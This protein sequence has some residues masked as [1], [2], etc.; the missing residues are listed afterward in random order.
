MNRLTILGD[1]A[2]RVSIRTVGSPRVTG[3]SVV[4]ASTDEETVR[5]VLGPSTPKWRDCTTTDAA[6]VVDLLLRHGIAVGAMS[7]NK[8]TDHWRAFAEDSQVLQDAIVNQSR[9]AAG[10]AKPSVVLSFI[11]LSGSAAIATGLALRRT[12]GR[13][14]SGADGLDPIERYLIFDTEVSGAESVEVF[15]AFW[16][17]NRAP[18]SRLAQLGVRMT[19]ADVQLLSEQDEPLLLLADY[20]AG[21]IHSTLLPDPGKLPMPVP[22]QEAKTLT[23]KLHDAGLLEVDNTNFDKSYDEIFGEVMSHARELK[24]AKSARGQSVK[25]KP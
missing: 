18:R 6:R 12:A 13:R 19:H 17:P 15:K 10:W 7:V 3:A 23:R 22:H 2:G 20:A 14:V 5:A 1:I 21:L 16:E 25:P 9:S 24:D 8:D 4:I 11:L